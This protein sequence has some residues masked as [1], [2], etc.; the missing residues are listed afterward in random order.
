MS[1]RII[2]SFYHR[3]LKNINDF[4]EESFHENHNTEVKP[5]KQKEID[6]LKNLANGVENARNQADDDY[7]DKSSQAKEASSEYYRVAEVFDYI[8]NKKVDN[9][10]L[11]MTEQI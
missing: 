11:N 6:R 3:S 4:F 7:D 2:L 1:Y 9:C 8:T 5:E 10:S